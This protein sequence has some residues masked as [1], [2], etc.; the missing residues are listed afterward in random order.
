MGQFA[1]LYCIG[2]Y[3][4]FRYNNLDHSMLT[5]MLALRA[6]LGEK[7]DPWSVNP[8]GEY[9]EEKRRED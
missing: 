8:E 1:N 3:G 6:L 9:I 2:R 4:Q 5:G 7:V